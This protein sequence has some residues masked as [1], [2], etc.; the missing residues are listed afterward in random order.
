[1]PYYI[2]GDLNQMIEKIKREKEYIA[3]DV[4]LRLAYQLAHGLQIIHEK[5]LIHRDIK[6]HNIYMSPVGKSLV[7]GKYVHINLLIYNR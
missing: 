3:N 7:I 5:G 6:P 2:D 4:I 1:M